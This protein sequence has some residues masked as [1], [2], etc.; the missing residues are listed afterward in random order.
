MISDDKSSVCGEEEV[1]K[2][3]EKEEEYAGKKDYTSNMMEATI[4]IVPG[5]TES[6]PYP[7]AEEM[8]AIRIQTA[9]RGFLV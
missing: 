8:A 6:E 4:A 1:E 3:N 2:E 7:A 9:F 5:I